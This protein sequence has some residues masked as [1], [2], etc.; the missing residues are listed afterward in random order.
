M[1][2]EKLNNISFRNADEAVEI[3]EF[4]K[5]RGFKIKKEYFDKSIYTWNW[6]FSASLGYLPSD[7]DLK[8]NSFT[9]FNNNEWRVSNGVTLF[10]YTINGKSLIR[11]EKL[12]N[13]NKISENE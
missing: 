8:Y 3:A 2:L 1:E 11:R 12:L 5:S 13:L 6:S 10:T 9:R 7:N 4:L